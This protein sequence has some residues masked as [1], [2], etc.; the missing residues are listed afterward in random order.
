[1]ESIRKHA[2]AM[3]HFLKKEE[4][5]ESDCLCEYGRRQYFKGT[6]VLNLFKIM[7]CMPDSTGEIFL[8]IYSKL[9]CIV[10]SCEAAAELD[11]H[12]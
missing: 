9:A 8:N 6:V 1:M 12:G 2:E 10:L 3:G 4:C 11:H 7:S 5:W